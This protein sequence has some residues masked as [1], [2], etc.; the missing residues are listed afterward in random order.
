MSLN[1]PFKKNICTNIIEEFLSS[2]T[3]ID[4]VIK[5]EQYIFAS[6]ANRSFVEYLFYLPVYR[7]QMRIRVFQLKYKKYPR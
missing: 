6:K 2:V 3:L 1:M 5:T 4:E 7:D